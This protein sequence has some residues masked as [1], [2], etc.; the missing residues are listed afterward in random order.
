MEQVAQ[1]GQKR[2]FMSRAS[3][4]FKWLAIGALSFTLVSGCSSS[5]TSASTE[6]TGPNIEAQIKHAGP[7]AG[8]NV[9]VQV[10]GKTVTLTGTVKD[11]TQQQIAENIA[12]GIAKDYTVTN[13]LQTG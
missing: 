1:S 2:I 6:V 11:A 4:L 12:K 8:S 10:S 3:G 13:Q 9:S 7:M 5:N